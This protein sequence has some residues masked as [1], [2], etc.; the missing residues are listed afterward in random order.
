MSGWLCEVYMLLIHQCAGCVFCTLYF[1]LFFCFFK[2]KTAYEMRIS[3][4]S[5]DVCSSDLR[6]EK[7]GRMQKL[8]EGFHRFQDE[9]FGRYKRLFKRLSTGGQKPHKIGRDSSRERVCQY[10]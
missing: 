10:V 3:D 7:V 1:T 4:W 6:T 8:I 2:Q 9:A 5:S